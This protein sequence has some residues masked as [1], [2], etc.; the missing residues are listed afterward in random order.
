M[1]PLSSRATALASTNEAEDE[2][3]TRNDQGRPKYCLSDAHDDE[4]QH[5]RNGEM[6]NENPRHEADRTVKAVPD[7][8]F[9]Q[10]PVSS[11][12]LDE[13]GGV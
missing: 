3:L 8:Q 5:H 6:V 11:R 13:H 12:L 9:G 10:I 1:S 2:L 7:F 4:R